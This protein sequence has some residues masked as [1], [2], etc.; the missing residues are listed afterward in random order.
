MLLRPGNAGS[1]TFTDHKRVLAA[2]IQQI[3]A[4]FRR[5]ILTRVDGAGTSHELITQPARGSRAS[6]RTAA[7]SRT[8]GQPAAGDGERQ[9]GAAMAAMNGS[10]SRTPATP[11]LD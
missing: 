7:P 11:A 10:T 2:A 9:R 3:A 8:W 1:N 5:K 6:P 4:W